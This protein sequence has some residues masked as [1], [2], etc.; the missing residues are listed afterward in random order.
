[1]KHFIEGGDSYRA[2]SSANCEPDMPV[3]PYPEGTKEHEDWQQGFD[4][5]EWWRLEGQY[6]ED[7]E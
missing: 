3:N 7:V 5:A 1:M 4:D 2:W 6:M